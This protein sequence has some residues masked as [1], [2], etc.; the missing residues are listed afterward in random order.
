MRKYYVF[1][2]AIVVIAFLGIANAATPH[3]EAAMK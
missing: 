2:L 3:A 1:V